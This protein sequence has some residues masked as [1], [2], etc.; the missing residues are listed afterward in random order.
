[1]LVV[2][3]EQFTAPVRRRRPSSAD[4]ELVVARVL[5]VRWRLVWWPRPRWFSR[6]HVD[7]ARR[8]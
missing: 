3:G 1:M 6:G 5:L 2:E 8:W 7:A 4:A